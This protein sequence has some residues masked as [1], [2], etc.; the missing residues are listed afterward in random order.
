MAGS[1]DPGIALGLGLLQGVTEFLPVSSSGHLATFAMFVEVPQMSLALTVL[2]HA[3]TLLATLI[4][5]YPDLRDLTLATARHATRPGELLRTGEGAL[6]RDIVVAC[7]PTG[8][9][10]L[11]LEAHMDQLVR[12]PFVVGGGFFVSALAA[13]LTRDRESGR[14]SL[15]VGPALVVGII[16]GL[17]V[18]PGVS[19]SGS[20]IACALLLGASAPTAFRFSF[21]VSMP[22]IA[23]A[24]ALELGKPGVAADLDATAWLAAA[25][26]F[27]VG[28]ASLHWLRRLLTRGRF[29][30]FAWYLIPL[31]AAMVIG[32]LLGAT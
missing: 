29:W 15:G 2:L 13:Y 22:V 25:I 31:G 30:L 24:T 23:G 17:A 9:I 26:T 18:L 12:N 20:T 28:Y 27:V 1:T 10:G 8:L 21:L 14:D 6:L 3:A 19:R 11:S 16:Q 32:G 7:V 5:F 4:V